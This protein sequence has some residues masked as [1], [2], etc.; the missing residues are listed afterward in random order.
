MNS[1]QT[2]R[3]LSV[4]RFAL[5]VAALLLGHS[6]AAQLAAPAYLK[7]RQDP[8]QQTLSQALLGF[9]FQKKCA[10][11]APPDEAEYE[12]AINHANQVFIGY[13]LAKGF[14]TQPSEAVSYS[15]EMAMGAIG[16]A[17]ANHC[18]EQARDKVRTG[19]QLAANFDALIDPYLKQRLE[20]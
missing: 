13:A 9:A 16:F 17:A 14:V 11:E 5:A 18:D 20:K 2:G 19:H 10:V 8:V 3:Q 12:R 4:G 1:N 7:N 15:R 6:A